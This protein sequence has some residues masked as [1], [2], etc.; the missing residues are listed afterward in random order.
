MEIGILIPLII[1]ILILLFIINRLRKTETR[2]EG[3]VNRLQSNETRLAGKVDELNSKV[4]LLQGN[5]RALEGEVNRLQSNETRLAGKVDELNSKVNLL[6]KTETRLE[7]EVDRLQEKANNNWTALSKWYREEQGWICESCGINLTARREFLDTH[8]VR[9]RAF[10]TPDDLKALCVKCHSDQ[11][12]PVD[13]SFMKDKPKYNQFMRFSQSEIQSRIKEAFRAQI[14]S[15]SCILRLDPAGGIGRSFIDYL[16]WDYRG[17]EIQLSI[18]IPESLDKIATNLNISNAYQ[19][20]FDKL[21]ANAD[22]I[23]RL[24]P[25]ERVYYSSLNPGYRIGIPTNVD[26]R[27]ANWQATA[28]WAQKNL[29]KLHLLIGIHDRL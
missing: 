8:H 10:E 24:F 26:L 15:D 27:Q 22:K 4:N 11:I 3:E 9:G 20:T 14:E 1:T 6:Q 29:E 5:K 13:H 19:A 17:L 2:L 16:C 18:W 12:L 28:K 7:G 23:Q 25:G 21:K